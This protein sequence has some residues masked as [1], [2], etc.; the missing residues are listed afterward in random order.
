MMCKSR[1]VDILADIGIFVCCLSQKRFFFILK[2]TNTYRDE[3]LSDSHE[4]ELM[5]MHT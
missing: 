3:N 1:R 4:F 5:G 2:I